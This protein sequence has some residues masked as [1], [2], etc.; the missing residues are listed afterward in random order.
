MNQRARIVILNTDL[1]DGENLPEN[2]ANFMHGIIFDEPEF[3]KKIS[4]VTYKVHQGHF[5]DETEEFDGV[6]ITGG[7]TT[8]HQGEPILDWVQRLMDY[9]RLLDQR[10]TPVLGVCFG[11][12]VITRTFGGEIHQMGKL[13]DG[14]PLYELGYPEINLTE[15]GRQCP[16][17]EG[18][19]ATF[20]AD[21]SHMLIATKLPEKAELL[22]QNDV[23]YQAFRLRNMLA[24][25]FHP[26]VYLLPAIRS[27]DRRIQALEPGPYR[28]QYI[29]ARERIEQE[30]A[31]TNGNQIVGIYRN[32]INNYVLR[33][34][35]K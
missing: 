16:L 31:Q 5:P 18:M 20:R 11:L 19:P 12:D 14:N 33:R 17:F 34:E 1:D 2:L 7:V 15:Q 22:A 4:L 29:Q 23:C 3:S 8:I 28:D 35:R 21:Q 6:L 26:E 30:Y 24:I 13:E 25:Q 27:I 9:L 32:F 10:G